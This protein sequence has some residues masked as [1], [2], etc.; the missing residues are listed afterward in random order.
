M[1]LLRSYAVGRA[2]GPTE[3]NLAKM[4]NSGTPPPSRKC[5]NGGFLASVTGD[6]VFTGA[7]GAPYG[8]M[9]SWFAGRS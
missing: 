9:Q 6:L 8:V 1:G 4:L 5:K 7:E 2:G 3:R